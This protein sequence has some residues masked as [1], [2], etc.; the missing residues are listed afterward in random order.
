MTTLSQFIDDQVQ[1]LNELGDELQEWFDN[2]P[3]GLQSSDKMK[4]VEAAAEVL[5]AVEPPELHVDFDQ[6][7]LDAPP[8]WKTPKTKRDRVDY[9]AEALRWVQE[10]TEAHVVHEETN[11]LVNDLA[12]IIES[13]EDCWA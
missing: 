13:V 12:T 4:E 1:A 5:S 10:W 7:E 3:E 2:S 9:H 8:R 11:T 6:V